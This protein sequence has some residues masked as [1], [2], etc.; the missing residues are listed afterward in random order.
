M[1]RQTVKSGE[2]KGFKYYII[3]IID[4]KGGF[5]GDWSDSRHWFC[6]YV[7]IAKDR[8]GY[9]EKIKKSG[10]LDSTVITVWI[11]QKLKM[12]SIPRMN[13]NGL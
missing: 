8:R 2:Y 12:R 10:L 3:K 4:M 6:G 9:K 13:A 1:S 5:Y 7:V 11:I